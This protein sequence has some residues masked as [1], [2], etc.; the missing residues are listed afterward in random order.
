MAVLGD[1]LSWEQMLRGA[2]SV[3]H[4]PTDYKYILLDE[5]GVTFIEGSRVKVIH[6][7]GHHI[8]HGLSP[9][10]LQVELPHLTMSQIYSA[11]AYY[12]D[13]KEEI[14]AEEERLLAEAERLRE[15]QQNSPFGERLRQIKA[16]GLRLKAERLQQE[17]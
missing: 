11:F 12:W 6:L 14:D 3:S 2:L 13:N 9:E 10:E 17:Q 1:R 4:T 16:E 7:V 15:E 8:G 5:K